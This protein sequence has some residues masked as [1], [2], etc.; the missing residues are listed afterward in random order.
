[1]CMSWGPLGYE[2]NGEVWERME[3]FLYA[4]LCK[5]ILIIP[6]LEAIRSAPVPEWW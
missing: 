2:G 1:M 5:P 3:R 4:A 6:D